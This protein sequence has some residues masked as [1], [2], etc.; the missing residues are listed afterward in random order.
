VA[1]TIADL[2]QSEQ[3]QSAHIAEA[4]QYRRALLQTG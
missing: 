1:R 4:A 3:V 2:A